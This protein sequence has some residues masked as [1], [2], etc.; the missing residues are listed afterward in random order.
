VPS[1]E[2]ARLQEL[3]ELWRHP[4]GHLSLDQ[5]QDLAAWDQ[6]SEDDREELMKAI[7][8]Q[9]RAAVEDGREQELLAEP[10]PASASLFARLRASAWRKR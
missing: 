5:M 7:E 2:V 1:A 6:T 9:R 4:D 8:D 3:L 10:K